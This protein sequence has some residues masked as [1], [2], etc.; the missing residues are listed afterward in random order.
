M[1]ILRHVDGTWRKFVDFVEKANLLEWKTSAATATT[2]AFFVHTENNELMVSCEKR[3]NRF[4]NNGWANI[5]RFWQIFPEKNAPRIFDVFFTNWR[6]LAAKP[7]E[8]LASNWQ[9]LVPLVKLFKQA[10]GIFDM[11][12][13]Y[14]DITSRTWFLRKMGEFDEKA[15]LLKWKTSTVTAG[16][17]AFFKLTENNEA[18]GSCEKGSSRFILNGDTDQ[19]TL[20]PARFWQIFPEKIAP[21][22]FDAFSHIRAL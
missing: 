16:A 8:L 20:P 5:A 12:R 14:G 11:R 1:V 4:F 3:S 7:S 9:G 15:I 10:E 22:T 13:R 6:S 21:R 17:F 19:Q 18:M 2:F